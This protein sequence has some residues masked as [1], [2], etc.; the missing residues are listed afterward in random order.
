MTTTSAWAI[1]NIPRPASYEST[2]CTSWLGGSPSVPVGFEWP[3]T[4]SDIVMHFVGQFDL[5]AFADAA[6]GKPMP[7]LPGEGAILAFVGFA[8]YKGMYLKFEFVTLSKAETEEALPLEAPSDLID[9][10]K[11][12]FGV[13]G[14]KFNFSP[15]LPLYFEDGSHWRGS[16]FFGT[17]TDVNEHISLRDSQPILTLY[18][19]FDDN[20]TG[21]W[22]EH[23]KGIVVSGHRAH[24]KDGDLNSGL[25]EGMIS[26]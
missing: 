16:R 5:K 24:I 10:H 4:Q 3:E 7:T 14:K 22:R 19:D 15:V 9:L 2:R 23:E 6:G 17:D 26:C 21:L 20:R 25:C 1:V 12:G 8:D 11:V 13:E 18:S